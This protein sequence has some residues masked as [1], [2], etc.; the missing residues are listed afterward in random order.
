MLTKHV[1]GRVYNYDYCIGRLGIG[2]NSFL[3]AVD[4]A[5]GSAGSL[6]VLSRGNEFYPCHGITKCTLD[7]RFLWDDRGDSFAGGQAVWPS[8]VAVDSHEDLYVSDEYTCL[9]FRYD[10]DGNFLGSWGGRG[11]AEGELNAPSGLAFDREDNLYVVDSLNHR[12]QVFTKEGRFLASWGGQ[13]RGEGRFDMP[14][15][16]ALDGADNV[17]VADWKNDRVQKFSHE[18]EYLAS[19]GGAAVSED[20]LQRP[21]DVAIDAE[22]DVYVADWGSNRLNI[23]SPDGAFVTSFMGDADR[24][25][26]WAW[27]EVESN[28]DYVKARRRVDLTPERLFLR[29]VAVNVDDE[30][31]IMVLETHR[32]RIQ[33]YMKERG[34]VDA[35]FNL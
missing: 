20:G 4:F 26:P 33:V 12:V 24:L 2:G 13:G 23:Y 25:S 5:L 31:R 28:P 32:H 19:F 34:F 15:G 8:S 21:T 17:Y 30:G 1:A 10:R 7:H 9:I 6:Y 16:I 27:A 3:Y 29:P 11:T 22:G 18:G 35:Q 14:W